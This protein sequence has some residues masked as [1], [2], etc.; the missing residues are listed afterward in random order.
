MGNGALEWLRAPASSLVRVES[1]IG[2]ESDSVDQGHDDDR[3]SV[4]VSGE[5]HNPDA[6][7]CDDFESPEDEA[8]SVHPHN[9]PATIDPAGETASAEKAVGLDSVN[10]AVTASSASSHADSTGAETADP[11]TV[12]AASL[13]EDQ[14]LGDEIA[15]APLSAY[16]ELVKQ[17]EAAKLL[18]YRASIKTVITT[19]RLPPSSSSA[20][21]SATD[22]QRESGHSKHQSK[23]NDRVR[24]LHLSRAR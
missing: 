23:L 2:D 20:D 10:D 14:I 17:V 9:Q 5:I 13:E 19:R 24:R 6:I 12:F 15:A 11:H 7:V 8:S 1:E 18:G 22:Y 3:S 21:H 16:D 4:E